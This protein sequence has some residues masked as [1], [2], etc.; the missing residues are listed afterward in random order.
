MRVI[1]AVA[2]LLAGACSNFVPQSCPAGLKPMTKAE[3][4]FGRDIAGT[5]TVSDAD[6]NSFLDTEV[7]PRFPGG[8]TVEDASGQWKGEHRIV[9]EQS[10][11]LTLVLA[12]ASDDEAKLAA[13][14]AAYKQ[15]FRQ[16]S[17]LV[18]EAPACGAF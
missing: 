6:W 5:A 7:T 10:K 13:I 12:G 4:F 9:R 2:V 11:R 15:R 18:L 17:V 3:L 8:L 1:W 14:R 16:E